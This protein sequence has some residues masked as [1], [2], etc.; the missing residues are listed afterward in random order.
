VLDLSGPTGGHN[1]PMN[2]HIDAAL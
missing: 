2:A 1:A